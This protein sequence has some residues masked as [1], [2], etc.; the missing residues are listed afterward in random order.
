[1]GSQFQR[2]RVSP[3][4]R[5]GA[6]N[7][8]NKARDGPERLAGVHGWELRGCN[9]AALTATR[10]VVE[11][12]GDPRQTKD[13]DEEMKATKP[14]RVAPPSAAG[15]QKPKNADHKQGRNED[16]R[17]IHHHENELKNGE[18]PEPKQGRRVKRKTRE[19]KPARAKRS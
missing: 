8:L 5:D 14:P 11:E 15:E 2:A 1:M 13:S 9:W 10:P 19:N 16:E 4:L 18:L 3:K 7:C 17:Q 6:V 12:C